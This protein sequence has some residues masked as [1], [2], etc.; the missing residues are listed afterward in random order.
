M[1]E[2][3]NVVNL[4]D[5]RGLRD[6]ITVMVGGAPITQAF[7]D[8][9]GADYYSKDAATAADIAKSVLVG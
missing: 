9:I 4:L 8:L 7:C 5:A 3:K 2:M 6:K 1:N